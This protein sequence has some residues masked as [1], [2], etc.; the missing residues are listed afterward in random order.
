MLVGPEQTGKKW[1]SEISEF[2]LEKMLCKKVATIPRFLS[3]DSPTSESYSLNEKQVLKLQNDILLSDILIFH[4]LP[5]NLAHVREFFKY[6]AF[7]CRVLRSSAAQ[8]QAC[9]MNIDNLKTKK[10]AF[11]GLQIIALCDCP[12]PHKQ[13]FSTSSSSSSSSSSKKKAEKE[14][15]IKKVH[16]G[17]KV[18]VMQT[19]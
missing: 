6:V 17:V 7:L 8:M 1:V 15:E 10:S 4:D 5:T 13:F 3:F 11:G 14:G 19:S 9:G 12:Q 16:D 18:I 2:V